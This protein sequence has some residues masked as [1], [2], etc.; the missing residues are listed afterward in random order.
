M[1]Q[2]IF[3]ITI[4]MQTQD[5]LKCLPYRKEDTGELFTRPCSF[6]G[7]AMLESC[8]LGDEDIKIVTVR[9]NDDNNRTNENYN[10]FKRELQALSADLGRE[11][12][13]NEEIIIPHSENKDKQFQLYKEICSHYE[14]GADIYMDIT[15]GT[16]VTSACR[17]ST[18]TY[19]EK[20]SKCDIKGVYYG[21]IPYGNETFGELYNVSCLYEL[22]MLA[23]TADF[24]TK[25]RFDSLVKDL[26]G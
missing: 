15:Y 7:I 13:I 21:K 4:S 14:D 6:P 10:L 17:F 19:A 11:L 22:S 3:F 18:L 20:I 23:N 16:K 1:N 12:A 2:K 9:T 25:E 8:I 5:N 24:M 26:W